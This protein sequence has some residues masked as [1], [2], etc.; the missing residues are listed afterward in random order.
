MGKYTHRPI[1]PLKPGDKVMWKDSNGDWLLNGRIYTVKATE[2][3]WFNLEGIPVRW[4]WDEYGQ[5]EKVD[6]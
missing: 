3:H 5:F 1:A 2:G 6:N 4:G